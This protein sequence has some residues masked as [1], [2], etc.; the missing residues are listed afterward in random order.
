MSC[1]LK[2]PEKINW[3]DEK[4][5]KT[6]IGTQQALNYFILEN[7]NQKNDFFLDCREEYFQLCDHYDS[8]CNEKS[9][10]FKINVFKTLTNMSV[11]ECKTYEDTAIKDP[12]FI[13]LACLV[14]EQTFCV[15]NIFIGSGLGLGSG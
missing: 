15:Q 7:G 1:G 8:T 4:L 6:T 14:G 13:V 5:L 9:E 12:A 3:C 2:I 10:N 11:F